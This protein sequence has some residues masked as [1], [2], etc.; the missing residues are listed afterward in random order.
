[1]INDVKQAFDAMQ[2]SLDR[3]LELV[4]QQQD[5]VNHWLEDKPTSYLPH[6]LVLTKEGPD[7][8]ECLELYALAVE[9]S[10]EE[11]KF[12]TLQMIGREIHLRKT[13]PIAAVLSAEAWAASQSADAPHVQPRDHPERRE[14]IVIFGRTLMGL[15]ATCQAPITRDASDGMTLGEFGEIVTE[16]LRMRLLDQLFLGFHQGIEASISRRTR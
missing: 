10:E 16:R 3:L 4:R 8:K 7:A 1:M 15:A 11:E 6:L 14:V 2:P 5:M 13:F 12:R 9:F